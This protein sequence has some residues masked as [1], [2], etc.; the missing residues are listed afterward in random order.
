[1]NSSTHGVRDK[2]KQPGA[3]LLWQLVLSTMITQEYMKALFAR[4]LSAL[5]DKHLRTIQDYSITKAAWNELYSWTSEQKMIENID[6]CRFRSIWKQV[7]LQIGD[8]TSYMVLQLTML[9]VLGAAPEEPLKS[10]L[11]MYSFSNSNMYESIII[12]IN[13]L[14]DDMSWWS[15]LTNLLIEEVKRVGRKQMKMRFRRRTKSSD[16]CIF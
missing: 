4:T 13:I 12:S 9:Q 5:S 6:Y 16:S 10:A 11:L 14:A 1:M 3:E 8:H 7:K 2:Q 15:Y